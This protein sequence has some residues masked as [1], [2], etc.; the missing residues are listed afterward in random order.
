MSRFVAVMNSK[1]VRW[2]LMATTATTVLAI[3]LDI[4]PPKIGAGVGGVMGLLGMLKW[5]VEGRQQKH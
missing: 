5:H 4:V 1:A 2:T 3:I